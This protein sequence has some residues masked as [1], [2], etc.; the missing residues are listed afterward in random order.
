M[1]G[2]LVP[3]YSNAEILATLRLPGGTVSDAL[4]SYTGIGSH[5]PTKGVYRFSEFGHEVL[6]LQVDLCK[7]KGQQHVD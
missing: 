3:F 1:E 6:Q 7:R 2:K 4:C 5:T